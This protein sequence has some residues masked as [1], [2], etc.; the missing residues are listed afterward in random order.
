LNELSRQLISDIDSAQ[1]IERRLVRLWPFA[2]R[3]TRGN[4]A[5]CLLIS[6]NATDIEKLYET[7]QH[8]IPEPDNSEIEN[9]SRPAIVVGLGS[10][11]ASWYWETVR[12]YVALDDRLSSIEAS[13][14][15]VITRS[16]RPY[17]AIGAS[18]AIAWAASEFT[19]ELVAWRYPNRIGS[20]RAVDAELIGSISVKH[21]GTFANRDPTTG[22]CL[23]APRTPC[24]VLYGIRGLNESSVIDAH[25]DLQSYDSIEESIEY[26]I[27]K[28]NQC[29]DDHLENTFVGTVTSEPVIGP[30][31]HVSLT[32]MSR[33][34]SETIL[35]FK[36]GGPVNTE[37]RLMRAGDII[38][39][40]GLRSPDDSIHLERVCLI[41]PVPVIKNRP[42]CCGTA[43]KSAGKGS[44]LR[45]SKCEKKRK[46][47]WVSKPL[48]N[49]GLWAE[50][51]PSHRRHIAKP[52]SEGPPDTTARMP[53]EL[54][55]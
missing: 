34:K 1:E 14:Y 51:P 10:A 41:D 22:R 23:I 40:A 13:D 45:C 15:R 21:P 7:L 5:L 33:G 53:T 42:K 43:M 37:V 16:D 6:I 27:H 26:G 49:V 9:A 19:W 48:R 38:C 54:P 8:W 4:A 17:G 50:P 25:N 3:R 46:R 11:P 12:G 2:E 31:G 18:A 29:S 24:P 32:A 30:G 55:S 35:A 28:T 39:W 36:E 52:L 47:S 20:P 44:V